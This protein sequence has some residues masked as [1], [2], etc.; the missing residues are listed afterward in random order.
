MG[1]DGVAKNIIWYKNE[2]DCLIQSVQEFCCVSLLQAGSGSDSSP[3]SPALTRLVV[4]PLC[5]GL[6]FHRKVQEAL[7]PYRFSEILNER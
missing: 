1:E 4:L 2:L 3:I 7:N 5:L 6:F